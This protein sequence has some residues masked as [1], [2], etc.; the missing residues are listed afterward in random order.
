MR[1]PR[2]SA[3]LTVIVPR[4]RIGNIKATTIKIIFKGAKQ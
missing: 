3:A 4:E 2:S 1:R